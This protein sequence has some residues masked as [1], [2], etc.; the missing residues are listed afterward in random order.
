[1]TSRKV[2][3]N[4]RKSHPIGVSGLFYFKLNFEKKSTPISEK[5]EGLGNLKE[6][7]LFLTTAD[8]GWSNHP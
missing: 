8:K 1:M 3:S 4:Y 7:G 5:D 6:A 2:V